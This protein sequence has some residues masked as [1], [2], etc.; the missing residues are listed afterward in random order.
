MK[1]LFIFSAILGA[2][3]I[4]SLTV[5]VPEGQAQ[6]IETG[7]LDDLTE[8][9]RTAAAGWETDMKDAAE[10]LLVSLGVI[11]LVFSFGFMAVKGNLDLGEIYATFLRF[12]IVFGLFYWFIGNAGGKEGIANSI[13]KSFEKLAGGSPASPST[14]VDRGFSLAL[15]H[16]MIDKILIY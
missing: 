9:F 13:I 12:V 3:L 7:F 4:V 5:A 10:I 11:S 6:G 8:D 2:A 14:L 1:K 16:I 15:S